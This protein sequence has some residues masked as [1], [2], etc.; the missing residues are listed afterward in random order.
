MGTVTGRE[1][2]LAAFDSAGAPEFG[3]VSCY[4]GIFIRDH[5]AAITR[6][7][8]W[9]EMTAPVLARDFAA[10][11]GLDWLGVDACAS[12]AERARRR[13]EQRAD[14][15]WRVDAATGRETRLEPP[16]PGG[17]NTGCASSQHTDPGSL[18]TTRREIDALVP[19]QPDFDRPAFLAEG[20]QDAAVAVRA[21]A[22]ELLLYSHI[23]SPLWSLYLL[24]GYE[25]M[26]VL[27]GQDPG[28]AAYA[29]GRVAVNT[30]QRIRM[31]AA[32]GA[33][34]VWIEECITDQISPALY[35]EINVPL[36]QRCA[37]EIRS[38]GMKSIYY[39][40]GNPADRLDS[41]LAAGADAI[42]FE[43]S[44]KNFTID[45]AEVIG[46]VRGRCVVFGNLDALRLLQDGSGDALRAEVRRQL[47]AGRANGGRF[48][49]S[50]GSPIT[51]ATSVD[52]VRR[53]ADIA[54][55][56]GKR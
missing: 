56:L 23:L 35:R 26:M 28:L 1:S 18:P 29:A 30:A 48:V 8:W 11:S 39:Y 41:I 45:I 10:A 22:P 17:T 4:E 31:I 14:G 16:L 19:L 5:Y 27:L 54:R 3:V 49:T 24:F 42:H 47:A 21:A 44:K 52:R 37:Q 53:Y 20:R 25:G 32:L 55:E 38:C 12:R 2:I 50:T 9:D 51:P 40:C 36:L 13:L 43:E 15:V 7:P 34:A 33:D 6:A 46:K